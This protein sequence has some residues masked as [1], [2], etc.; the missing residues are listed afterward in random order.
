MQ[1]LAC[2]SAS[3][4]GNQ[5]WGKLLDRLSKSTS[6][7]GG[8]HIAYMGIYMFTCVCT[9]MHTCTYVFQSWAFIP[10]SQGRQH[11]EAIGTVCILLSAV[12][13]ACVDLWD[14][15]HRYVCMYCVYVWLLRTHAQHCYSLELG[16][17]SCCSLGWIWAGFSSSRHSGIL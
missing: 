5:R 11:N 2:Q 8:I 7:T 1:G 16:V 3:S 4:R 17:L 10:I 9:F 12:L 6:A 13:S 15:P 14:W